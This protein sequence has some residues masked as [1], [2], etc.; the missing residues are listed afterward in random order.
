MV[1]KSIKVF[2][3]WLDKLKDKPGRGLILKHIDRMKLGNLGKVKNISRGVFEKKIY[4]GPGYRL[5]FTNN[6]DQLIILL[7]GG[8]K[9]SQQQ[10]IIKAIDLAKE[11]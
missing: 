3:E 9:S 4:Y 2:D 5:Y 7:C 1:V 6:G 8:D 11:I 10:D